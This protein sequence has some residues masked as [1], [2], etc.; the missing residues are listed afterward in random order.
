MW[1]KI[2]ATLEQ[3][4]Y[5]TSAGVDLHVVLVKQNLTGVM[6]PPNSIVTKLQ[7]AI[8]FYSEHSL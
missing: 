2:V 5:R 7:P 3:S 6:S 8:C 1:E 4:V